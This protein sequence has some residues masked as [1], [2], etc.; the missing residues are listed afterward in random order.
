MSNEHFV[1]LGRESC[2]WCDKAKEL[3]TSK[4]HTFH[5]FDVMEA[6]SIREFLIQNGMDTVPQVYKDGEYIGGYSDLENYLED[7]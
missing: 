4:D 6:D 5:Y 7:R 3:V 1:I 2:P